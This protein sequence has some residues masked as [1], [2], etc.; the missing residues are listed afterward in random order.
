VGA[1]IELAAFARTVVA[2]PDTRC[3]LPEV[4][5]GLVP[6]SGGTV[7]IP[8]RIGRHRAAWLG[9]SGD[10]IDVDT[11]AQWGLVDEILPMPELG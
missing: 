11:A 6:G 1:G 8:R 2:A 10:T 5:L 9:L 7:S 4:S 3:R